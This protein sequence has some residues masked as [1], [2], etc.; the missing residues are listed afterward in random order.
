MYLGAYIGCGLMQLCL[1]VP[2]GLFDALVNGDERMDNVMLLF[3]TVV[4]LVDD[5]IM[6][7]AVVCLM[8]D[9]I[10]FYTAVCLCF[11]STRR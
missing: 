5:V 2:T 1:L 3:Y 7:Y 6:F 10:W 4:C 11:C 8:D 9:V